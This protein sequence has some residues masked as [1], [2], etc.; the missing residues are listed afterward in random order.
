MLR[1]FVGDA[2]RMIR[3]REGVH[4]AEVGRLQHRHGV[5]G[6]VD[7]VERETVG[8]D[9]NASGWLPVVVRPTTCP[10]AVST[11]T[12]RLSPLRVTNEAPKPS[13]EHGWRGEL[14]HTRKYEARTS[15]GRFGRRRTSPSP[16][17]ADLGR[18]RRCRDAADRCPSGCVS[19]RAA[20]C[21]RGCESYLHQLL[22][23]TYL[24]SGVTDTYQGNHPDLAQR[25][26]GERLQSHPR[27][28]VAQAQ[29]AGTAAVV[30]SGSPGRRKFA[31]RRVVGRHHVPMHVIGPCSPPHALKQR[32]GCEFVVNPEIEEPDG[33]E[34]PHERFRP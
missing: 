12:T 16:R 1:R 10:V 18:C 4:H 25:L 7:D 31:P 14:P 20:C 27:V 30:G 21:S 15:T 17:H 6:V 33:R 9:R 22:T 29:A 8:R 2:D 24:S 28:H 3:N 5:R 26:D 13:F 23:S 34:C 32:P 11:A 19:P